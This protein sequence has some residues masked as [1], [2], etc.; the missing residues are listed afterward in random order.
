MKNLQIIQSRTFLICSVVIFLILTSNYRFFYEA[1][2]AFPFQ[3]NW[4]FLG[5]LAIVLG[6][7]LI[8]LILPFNN[9]WTLKPVL[10]MLL[11]LAAPVAYFSD[12]FSV[13]IDENMLINTMQTDT[14]EA[15]DL[16]SIGFFFYWLSIALLPA[17][18]IYKWP[19]QARKARVELFASLKMAG[20]SILT[21]VIVIFSF[22][23][24]YATF[25]RE[26]KFIRY[27]TNPA[28]PI[29][30]FIK[31]STKSAV[32]KESLPLIKQYAEGTL[33]R[34]DPHRELMI[35]VVGETARAENFALLGYDRPTNPVLSQMKNLYAFKH[36][37]SCG[38]STADSVPCMFSSFS[39][40]EY[41]KEKANRQENLLD[42]MQ[43]AGISVLWRDNNSSSKGVAD[44]VRY[45]NFK[46]SELNPN[47]DIECR[48]VGM[49]D[50]LQKYIDQQNGDILIVLHQMGSHGPLYSNRTPEQF[51]YFQPI[52]KSKQLNTC[53]QQAIVNAYDN[54][55]RYT[56]WFLGQVVN[57]LKQ[58]NSKFEA[59]M[60]YVS[61][62]GESLGEGGLYLHGLPY[63]LAP[64]T[65]THVPML[66]WLGE[67]NDVDK[68]KLKN[69]QSAELTQEVVWSTVLQYFEIE[70]SENDKKNSIFTIENH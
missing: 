8:L 13:I 39:R 60:L 47:C 29:Y 18:I 34:D 61:D 26:Y 38:T 69:M 40:E 52:C 62:H 7:V 31:L 3:N 14:A 43:R 28:F 59:A 6:A 58:N 49:L 46:T 15:G 23:D 42:V 27:Y 36:V 48:D 25:F 70:L 19:L 63:A 4:L 41:S 30:S 17:I 37:S 21:I 22:S 55:I 9:R 2:S 64:E 33:Q 1:E 53:D 66:V 16:L 10:I 11:F 35:L 32:T 51:A 24:S 12:Q 5:S 20:I 56:D 50:G 44:R 57:L 65:Q 68:L 45:E 67:Y 54:S